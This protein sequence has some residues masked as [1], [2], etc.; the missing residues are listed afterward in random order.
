MNRWHLSNVLSLIS[1]AWMLITAPSSTP[2]PSSNPLSSRESPIGWFVRP[3]DVDSL[4]TAPEF[5]ASFRSEEIDSRN[6]NE[7]ISPSS[8]LENELWQ[9]GFEGSFVNEQVAALT[10]YNGDL[11]AG[12]YFTSAGGLPATAHIARWDGN[13]WNA[14][15]GAT[16]N[17]TIYALSAYQGSLYAGGFFLWGGGAPSDAIA[18]WDGITWHGVDIGV[19]GIV[20]SLLPFGNKLILGG[21]FTEIGQ[22][23]PASR[24]AS[25]D[26]SSWGTLGP[27]LDNIVYA[28]AEYQDNLVAGGVFTHSGDGV[29]MSRVASW[30]GT[31]WSDVGG[32]TNGTVNAL[33]TFRGSLIVGGSFTSAGGVPGTSYIARWDGAV[34]HPLRTGVNYDVYSLLARG[35]SLF[36]GGR[37]TSASGV[38]CYAIA[39]WD[40]LSWK[41]VSGGMIS[42]YCCVP[43]EVDAMAL[44]GDRLVAG[45]WFTLA[46]GNEAYCLASWDRTS[47]DGSL[48]C[49]GS[50]LSGGAEAMV[51]YNGSL[52]VG[53]WFLWAGGLRVNG[54]ARWDGT[55]WI[56]MGTG[57]NGTVTALTVYGKDLIAGGYFTTMDGLNAPGIA[58]WDGHRWHRMASGTNSTVQA[59]ATYNSDLYAGGRFTQAGG[60]PVNYIARWDGAIWWDV[61]GGVGNGSPTEIRA[62]AVYDSLLVVTGVFQSA[63]PLSNV[64]SVAG[65]N[66]T[67]WVRLGSGLRAVD[68]WGVPYDPIGKAAEVFQDELV[69]GGDFTEAG[70]VKVPNI[71][72]WNGSTWDSLGNPLSRVHALKVFEGDLFAGGWVRVPEHVGRWDGLSWTSM[73]AGVGPSWVECLA[74][75]NGS[76][77]VGGNIQ[78]AG[79]LSS[80]HIARWTPNKTAV[81]DEVSPETFLGVRSNPF[82]GSAR[83][84]YELRH[85]GIV[86][87]TIYDVQ[88]RQ[89]KSLFEGF[90]PPGQHE[91][92]WTGR[93]D[94]ERSVPSGTYFLELR[95]E[96]HATVR[97]LVLSR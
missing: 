7:L 70:G 73:G 44:Y 79:A 19:G 11:I 87:L 56:P 74:T 63:G 38:S 82:R 45:G 92:I 33:T 93:D 36:V 12:G 72:Q 60:L 78:T 21:Y 2:E 50:G 39:L 37:F 55:T 1:I 89:I 76:L 84:F 41:P 57:T 96:G 67:T 10:T 14:M 62:L 95:S 81:G 16:F 9:P 47:W 27:G 91:L 64:G 34:W 22:N 32:G 25:W 59:L 8:N 18:R 5:P 31:T 30:N 77:Y 90:R 54:I 46:G 68:P 13:K 88:G 65:W 17:G 6:F 3:E 71:A 23:L 29:P 43:G 48:S 42:E 61:G 86:N 97:K 66:G 85:P 80:L 28:L 69:I 40:G 83:L 20:R 52:I 15:T 49:S 53:G 26:G 58:R 35:D 4:R 94:H 51:V 75:Y 24:I